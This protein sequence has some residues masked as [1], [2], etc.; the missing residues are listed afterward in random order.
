MV[1]AKQE[2][3]MTEDVIECMG[4]YWTLSLHHCQVQ[5]KIETS[6]KIQVYSL[7]ASV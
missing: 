6:E 3:G 1:A 2:Q 7:Y 5:K 4:N